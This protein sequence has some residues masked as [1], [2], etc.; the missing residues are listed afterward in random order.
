M[1]F[2]SF[3]SLVGAL[4]G[5]LSQGGIRSK[6][7][8]C[9]NSFIHVRAPLVCFFVAYLSVFIF[10]V[11]CSVMDAGRTQIAAGS[12]TV[13]AIG[14]GMHTLTLCANSHQAT[15]YKTTRAH[16]RERTSTHPSTRPRSHTSTLT[17]TYTS[18]NAQF[19]SCSDLRS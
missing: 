11:C 8:G 19:F 4:T 16:T 12:R 7:K 9:W 5:V 3:F 15:K 13:L 2:N 6:S 17:R 1:S 14:P 10:F 18:N